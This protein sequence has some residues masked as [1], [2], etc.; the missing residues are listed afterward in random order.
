MAIERR[1]VLVSGLV[2]GVFYRGTCAR[3]A[4][5]L[6]VAG[7]VRNLPDGRVEGVFEGEAEVVEEIVRWCHAGPRLARVEE[8][9][10][11]AEH[12]AGEVGFRVR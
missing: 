11:V 10:V 12:P 3:L 1:R 6:G 2:Q 5:E 4:R 8:V 9:V 7:W